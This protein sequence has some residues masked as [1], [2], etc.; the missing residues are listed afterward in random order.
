MEFSEAIN[1][2]KD[3]I[4]EIEGKDYDGI[5]VKIL[6]AT[7]TLD[8]DKSSHQTHIAITGEQIDIFPFLNASGYFEPNYDSKDD[9]LKSFFLLQIPVRLYRKNVENLYSSDSQSDLFKLSDTQY[10]DTKISVQ[11]SRRKGQSDQVQFSL[12]NYDSKEVKGFRKLLKTGD[13][14]VLLKYENEFKYDLFGFKQGSEEAKTLECLRNK[15]FKNRDA[16]TK[17]FPQQ[18][19]YINEDP[20]TTPENLSEDYL[21]DRLKN[22]YRSA[23]DGFKACSI[24]SFGIVFANY[25]KNNKITVANLVKKA[26]LNDSYKTELQTGI[27]LRESFE[28]SLFGITLYENDSHEN[29]ESQENKDLTHSVLR[30]TGGKNILLYGVPGSGKSYYIKQNYCNDQTLIERVVFHPEYTYSDFVGQIL[31]QVEE[32][33]LKYVFT[34]GPFTTIL[35][36]AYSN[37]AQNF[38]LIIEELNRGNA[39]AIFGEVFQLLDRDDNGE[40]EYSISNFDIAREIF[41]DKEH[42]IRIPSNL[43]II[44]TMNTS[45]QNVFT[46]DT[47]FQRRWEMKHIMNNISSSDLAKKKIAESEISWESFATTV[48]DLI[49]K[50]NDGASSS[51]DKRLGAYFVSASELKN[52]ELFTEKVFKYLWDDVFKLN[53]ETFF[54]ESFNSFDEVLNHIDSEKCP[55]KAV[56]RDEIYSS[57]IGLEES[58]NKTSSDN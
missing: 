45:D 47:A 6:G 53:R 5:I 49:I 51:E 56:V 32:D 9:S 57:M 17:V 25:I 21:V 42:K 41:N 11:G 26:D 30:V 2:V 15:F 37:P 55:I 8:S 20:N 34:P 1:L 7:N 40:S 39:P 22:M 50:D 23:R 43:W 24:H 16:V 38:Y 54:K 19:V 48:N 36:K 29:T 27:K 18:F 35:K 3:A 12:P 13:T 31:P 33:N 4:T 14:I 52:K 46:L 28:N 58:N 44:A 10:L